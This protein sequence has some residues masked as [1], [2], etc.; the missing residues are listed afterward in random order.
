MA[1]CKK[2]LFEKCACKVF[3]PTPLNEGLN[4]SGG[5]YGGG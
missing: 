1:K 2:K 3:M 5:F 4:R